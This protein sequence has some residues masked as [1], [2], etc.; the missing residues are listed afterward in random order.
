[1]SELVHIPQH[2]LP[3]PGS[4]SIVREAGLCLAL[5]HVDGKLYAI[6]DSCPHAG[7]SLVMGLLE[8]MQV[9]CPAHG[10]KFDI[11]TGCMPYGGG[12]RVRSYPVTVVDGQTFVS[13]HQTP[14][15]KTGRLGAF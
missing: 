4:R 15:C 14:E 13:L 5:F 10:L 9:R 12:M 11:R 1:M 6:D 8:D 7:G 2:K 3:A